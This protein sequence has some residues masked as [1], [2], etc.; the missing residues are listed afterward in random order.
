MGAATYLLHF[1]EPFGHARH[2]TGSTTRGVE[3]RVAEHVAGQGANLTALAVQVGITLTL[4]RT[5]DGD[6]AMETRLKY[7]HNPARTGVKRGMGR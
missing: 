6:R 1:S 3:E 4:A 2:Y 7:R 5:W